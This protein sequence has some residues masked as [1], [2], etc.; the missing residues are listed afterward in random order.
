MRILFVAM[1]ESIHTARWISQIQEQGWDVFLFPAYIAGSH[2]DIKNI[3]VFASTLP[4]QK[5][6]E[7]HIRL[8]WW[9][10]PF[11]WAD[12]II[13]KIKGAPTFFYTTKALALIIHWLK[14]DIVHSLEIQHAGYLTLEARKIL[15]SKFPVWIVTNWGSDIYL[16]GRLTEHKPRIEAVL[17]SCDYYSCECQ[18][19]IKLAKGLGFKG[20]TLPVFPNTGGFDLK[21]ASTLRSAELPASRRMILLKGYQHW[22]GRALVGLQALRLCVDLLQNY[23]IAISVASPEV[24]IVAELF[25]QDTGIPIKIIQP[26]PHEAML[27]YYGRSRIYIGLSISD[28]ISTSLLEAMVMGAFPIQSCTACADE[29]IKDGESGFIVPPEDPAVIASAIRRALNDD[30]LVNRAAEINAK[31]AR[32]RLDYSIIQPQV[33][34]MYRDIYDERKE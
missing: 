25:S 15:K 13:S 23:T 20:K 9:T 26:I 2:S 21:E 19:D 5:S 12:F 24:R 32:E 34:K 11:F 4:G 18:R 3:S 28:A 22:A 31:T 6:R 29:W 10:I 27:R 33:V 16:F 17:A 8:I 30:A 1:P 14:P 7:N